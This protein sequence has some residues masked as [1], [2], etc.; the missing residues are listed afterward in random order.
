MFT[1]TF[2]SIF[3]ISEKEGT[4]YRKIGCFGNNVTEECSTESVNIL[5]AKNVTISFI[6]Y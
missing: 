6:C 5:A 1:L 3:R 2:R 4:F